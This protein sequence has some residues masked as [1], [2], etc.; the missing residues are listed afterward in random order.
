MNNKGVSTFAIAATY[1]GTVVGAGFA[2]GQEV[3]RFFTHFGL[4][5]FYGI[6]A[7]TVLFAV[8][9]A[10]I[11]RMGYVLRAD[12]HLQVV[13]AIAGPT[14]GRVL[15]WVITFFLFGGAAVMMAGSGAVFAEH[16]HLNR[17]LGTL[18]MALLSGGTVL[19]GMRGVIGSISAV[20]PILIGMVVVVSTGAILSNG[21]SLADLQWHQPAAA[22]APW[23]PISLFLYASYNLVL[24]IAVLAPLGKEA[25]S[26]EAAHWGGMIGGAALGAG[27]FLINLALVSG[28]P[29]TAGYEVP[30][31]FLAGQF[32]PW[33]KIVYSL[34]LWAEVYTTAV[35]SLFGLA[36]RFSK[37]GST[38]FVRVAA[39]GTLGA[40][41]ASQF[42]FSQMVGFLFPAVGWLGLVLI[43]GLI[44]RLFVPPVELR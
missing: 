8:L 9:G 39:V 28:L 25:R 10:L 41:V 40:L 7:A 15:D 33:V 12:S 23:W 30:M 16:W 22:A 1:V 44:Y 26:L 42:G 29:Q 35:G 17:F 27:A 24:S 36:V 34:V 20:A 2:T 13:K 38:Q 32:S 14:I 3:L 11:L 5:G 21:I 18:I 19:L 43:G 4:E 31:L 6:I 37:S